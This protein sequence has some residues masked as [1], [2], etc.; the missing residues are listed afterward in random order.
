V[1][2]IKSTG[3]SNSAF[4]SNDVEKSEYKVI[5]L[6]LKRKGDYSGPNPCG[7]G[8]TSGTENILLPGGSGGDITINYAE[9][10]PV[11]GLPAGYVRIQH[12]TVSSDPLN[13]RLVFLASNGIICASDDPPSIIIG[14]NTQLD[15]PTGI[16][17]LKDPSDSNNDEIIVA[18]SHSSS[19]EIYRRNDRKNPGDANATGDAKYRQSISGVNTNLDTPFGL[20]V[21]LDTLNNPSEIGVV[22]NGAVSGNASVTVYSLSMTND[23]FNR[24]TVNS[25][26]IQTITGTNTELSNPGGIYLDSTHDEILVANGLNNSVTFY[27]R[28]DDGNVAPIRTLIGSNTGL[29]SPCGFYMDTT[30]NEIGVTNNAKGSVTFYDR[31]DLLAA[32]VGQLIGGSVSAAG[33]NVNSGDSLTV[34]L[35]GDPAQPIQ[36]DTTV[37]NDGTKVAAQ[38]QKLVR[39]ISPGNPIYDNFTA[40]FDINTNQYTLTSG[41][42]GANSSVIVTNGATGAKGDEFMLTTGAMHT[43]VSNA[44]PL[45]TLV[46]SNTGLSNPCGIYLDTANNEI[47]VANSGNSTI[48]IFNRQSIIDNTDATTKIANIPPI[49]TIRGSDTGLSNPVGIYLDPDPVRDEIGVTNNGNDSITF[50]KRDGTGLQMKELPVLVNPS[51]QQQLLLQ[52]YYTGNVN[53]STGVVDNPTGIATDGY[54][55]NWKITDPNLRQPG[56]ASAAVLMPPVSMVLAPGP[57]PVDLTNGECIVP[58]LTFGC[59]VLTNFL[60]LDLTTNC[61]STPLI[62]SPFPAES[63]SYLIP[64]KLLGQTVVTKIN[65]STTTLTPNQFPRP[66]PILKK[67]PIATPLAE[68]KILWDYVGET[69]DENGVKLPQAGQP[70][71]IFSQQIQISLKK[72]I[73]Q[74]LFGPPPGQPCYTQVAGNAQTLVYSSSSLTPDIREV[75]DVK[76]NGCTIQLTDIDT[77]TFTVTD[78]MGTKFIYRWKPM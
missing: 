25:T 39:A 34:Q 53:P 49:R 31:G 67:D 11:T 46:G 73:D 32:F 60:V 27:N 43:G 14:P 29:S 33:I 15:N 57:C 54:A 68:G 69:I 24:W 56:D 59:A 26:P 16:G 36:F 13:F 4:A 22:N 2:V 72:H 61:G 6:V 55:F 63:G 28:T 52:Y 40:S 44:A 71:I 51:D 65:L 41:A 70:P 30:N 77:L 3:Q 66:I 9:P 19:L 45:R 21:G 8:D 50:N 76:N 10:H 20:F 1:D 7:G 5:R 75:D 42:A 78:A 23:P 35:N 64:A 62:T 38:I 48:T 47:G 18:N 74:Y 12:F 58:S 17:L 37:L